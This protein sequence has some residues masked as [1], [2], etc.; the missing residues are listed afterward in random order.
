[1]LV[2]QHARLAARDPWLKTQV[3]KLVAQV[4]KLV[5]QVS[6]LKTENAA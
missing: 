2:T 6:W 4:S 1:M 5:T 3:S